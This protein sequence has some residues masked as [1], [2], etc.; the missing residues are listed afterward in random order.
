MVFFM[1]K[2]YVWKFLKI[3]SNL[4][5][6]ISTLLMIVIFC[7]LGSVIEQDKD[8]SYYQI[9]YTPYKNI[10]IFFGIDHVFQTWWFIVSLLILILSLLCC[11]FSTQLPSL[12]NAR[13]WKFMYKIKS[14]KDNQ[15]FLS[16]INQY[17]F[18]YTNFIYSLL[19][20]NF[21]VFHRNS[22][23]YSYKG[24]YGRIAPVFVH[25]SII[26]ILFGSLI[27]LFFSFVVQEVVP[28]GE[29]FH[30]KNIVYSGYYSVLPSSFAYRVNNFL[31]D[32]NTDSSINQFFSLL[33]VYFSNRHFFGPKLIS[34]NHPLHFNHI[35]FYQT[36]WQI[37]AIRLTLC[38]NLSIQQNLVKTLIN[39]KTCWLSTFTVSN[40][41]QICFILFD[42][43]TQILVCNI[44]GSVIGRVNVGE[45]FYIN[46]I[47]ITIQDVITS[48]GLQIK[49]DPGIFIVYIGFFVMILS[50]FLSYLSYSQIWISNSIGYLQVVGSTN[51]ATLFFEHDI[52]YLKRLYYYYSFNVVNQCNNQFIL[53]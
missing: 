40:K 52:N 28:K 39:N 18:S 31:I 9:N 16:D 6:A 50:T 47:P 1:N 24:L 14:I 38:H 10:I 7:I 45:N 29:V 15:L 36:D 5:F 27:S 22:A 4:N 35:T 3:F 46:N 23:L 33:S 26:A 42:L 53:L 37:N 8:F 11:T 44:D 48:T 30:L 43:N 13:R 51:R 17:K 20:L 41:E 2:T 12:K 32:Y 49:I 21:F 34:V 25:F 19:R